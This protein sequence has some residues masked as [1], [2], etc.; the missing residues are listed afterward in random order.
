M[1]NNVRKQLGGGEDLN[2]TVNQ[3]TIR[4]K[5]RI[6]QLDASPEARERSQADV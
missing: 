6:S 3:S 4:F 5:D 2:A 1:K